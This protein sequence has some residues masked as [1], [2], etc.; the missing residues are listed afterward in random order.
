MRFETIR[1]ALHMHYAH[2]R[3][4]RIEAAYKQDPLV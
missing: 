1:N 3:K 2:M 4:T